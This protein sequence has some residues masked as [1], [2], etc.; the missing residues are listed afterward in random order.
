MEK[1]DF[2]VSLV[3]G[4]YFKK[5]KKKKKTHIYG[6]IKNT[7]N[8]TSIINDR[9]YYIKYMKRVKELPRNLTESYVIEERRRETKKRVCVLKNT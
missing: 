9:I 8:S 4:D 7:P 2:V 1:N 3:S 6:E 5:R